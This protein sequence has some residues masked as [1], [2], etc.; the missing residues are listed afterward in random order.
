V[1][2]VDA[3]LL[4][5]LK[6]STENFQWLDPDENRS[7]S[8]VLSSEGVRIEDQRADIEQQLVLEDLLALIGDID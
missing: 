4:E 5:L 2:A 6:K 3:N 7:P 1:K 8:E